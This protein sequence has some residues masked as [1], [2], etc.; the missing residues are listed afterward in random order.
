[1]PLVLVAC[2]LVL[3]GTGTWFGYR[4]ARDALVPAVRDGDPTR[5]ALDAT[6]PLH[7][8]PGIRRAV[9]SVAAAVAWLVLA[10]YGLY[11][12]QTGMILGGVA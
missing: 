4:S 10:L 5:A 3:A 9:R 1:M 7:A 12:A 11:L 8:R 6:R 2:G